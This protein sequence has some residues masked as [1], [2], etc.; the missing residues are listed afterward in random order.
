MS[1]LTPIL[2]SL[3]GW[4]VS[5]LLEE[6]SAYWKN[7]DI[8][9]LSLSAIKAAQLSSSTDKHKKDVAVNQLVKTAEHI[10]HK[11]TK[12]VASELIE[13]SVQRYLK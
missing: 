7:D 4:L 10:G 11:L 5:A 6:V 12:N 1:F 2:Q 3:L 13:R 8:K 9:S